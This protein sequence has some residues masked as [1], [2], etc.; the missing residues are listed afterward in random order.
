MFDVTCGALL[1]VTVAEF[2]VFPGDP[3]CTVTV[4]WH[5]TGEGG[6][7]PPDRV[8]AAEVAVAAGQPAP[9]TLTAPGNAVSSAGRV[10]TNEAPTIGTAFGFDSVRLKV[11]NPPARMVGTA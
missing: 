5:T 6:I 7:V 11:V 9:V 2:I 8:I 3:P 10:S 1:D 4:Y